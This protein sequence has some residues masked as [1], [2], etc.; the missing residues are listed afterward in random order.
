MLHLRLG[1]LLHVALNFITF[2]VGT[3]FSIVITFSGDTTEVYKRV[4][5]SR[6]EV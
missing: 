3:T 5:I 2:T 4:G 6:A 1:K